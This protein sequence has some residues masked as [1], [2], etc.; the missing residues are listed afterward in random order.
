MGA[1]K[2]WVSLQREPDTNILLS[3]VDLHAITVP[4]DPKTLERNIMEMGAALLACGVDPAQCALF[5]QS[6]IH[7]HAELGWVLFCKTPVTWL[8]RMH[9][10]KVLFG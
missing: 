5:R 8:T 10:W 1:I 9:Q 6:H 3:V 2:N 7:Q 4:Q